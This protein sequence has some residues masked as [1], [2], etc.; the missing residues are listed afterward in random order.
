LPSKSC[1]SPL[2][3]AESVADEIQLR[4]DSYLFPAWNS[5]EYHAD[6]Q[7]SIVDRK[8]HGLMCFR[9]RL[10]NPAKI[11]QPMCTGKGRE[12]STGSG[13]KFGSRTFAPL[14][15]ATIDSV[16]YDAIPF[17]DGRQSLACH[18]ARKSRRNHAVSLN[19]AIWCPR[20]A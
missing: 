3:F 19:S 7:K 12:W 10:H 13:G 20:L 14:P 16:N 11:P 15:L 1:I 2:R 6:C 4:A 8:P 17:R 18:V 5:G 9:N